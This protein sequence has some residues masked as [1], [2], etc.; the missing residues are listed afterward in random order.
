MSPSATQV[1]IWWDASIGAYRMT[2]PFNRSLV[3]ALKVSI[4][5]SDRSYDPITKVW[6][7]AER[8]LQ[9]TVTLIK[10]V[11]GGQPQVVSR[12][13]VESAAASQGPGGATHNIASAAASLDAVMIAFVKV[14]PFEAAQKAFRHAAMMLHPDRGGSMDKMATLNAT[15]QRLEKE[16]WNQ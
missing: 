12:Q 7:F 11:M 5:A 13:Q 10:G 4:P 1:R 15:W 14:L 16:L 2:S 3:D 8:H 9:P 6:T